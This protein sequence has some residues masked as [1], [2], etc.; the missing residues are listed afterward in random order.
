[1]SELK[2]KKTLKSGSVLK[3]GI[4]KVAIATN[5]LRSLVNVIKSEISNF[6]LS[7]ISGQEEVETV[8]KEN[9]NK[10]INVF[11]GI[12]ANEN[13]EK[14]ILQCCKSCTLNDERIT[15]ELFEDIDNR[16][17]YLEVLF[18]VCWENIKVFIPALQNIKLSPKSEM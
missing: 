6:D 12:I 16:K 9:M 10:L 14:L 1:M 7:K 17:D 2:I 3:I 5:L 11:C 4:P 18:Y 8:L 13:I 15:E